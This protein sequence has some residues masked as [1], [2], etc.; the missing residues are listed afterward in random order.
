MLNKPTI[1]YSQVDYIMDLA[2]EI[3]ADFIS[4]EEVRKLTFEEYLTIKD[5]LEDIRDQKNG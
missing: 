2:K 4:I 3:N 5:L 1:H